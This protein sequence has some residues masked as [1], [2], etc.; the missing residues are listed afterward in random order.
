MLPNKIKVTSFVDLLTKLRLKRNVG[1][2]LA[3]ITILGRR[4]L[5]MIR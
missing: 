2:P 3:E 4:M 1:L 5:I